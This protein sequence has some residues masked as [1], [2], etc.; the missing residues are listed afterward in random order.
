MLYVLAQGDSCFF[1]RG[2]ATR[3]CHFAKKNNLC[4][5]NPY[6]LSAIFKKERS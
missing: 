5:S 6:Q 1:V 4:D 3:N 2:A